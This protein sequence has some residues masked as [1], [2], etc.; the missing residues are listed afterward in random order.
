M[1]VEQIAADAAEVGLSLIGLAFPA[2]LPLI[3]VAKA[4]VPAII[5]AKPY[6]VKA[7]HDGES[8][9]AAAQKASPQ[10]VPLLKKLATHV[11][12]ANSSTSSA[13]IHLE[14]V[15]RVA[16]GLGRMTPEQE[17]HWMDAAT[18]PNDS[19]VGSG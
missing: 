5:A 18:P 19:R 14:N 8:A 17:R 1:D 16:V 6:I 15:T 4:A 10:L 2:A 13:G 3:A 9:F 7:V 11:P 12:A